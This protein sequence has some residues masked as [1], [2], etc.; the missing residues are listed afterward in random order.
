[1]W[2]SKW[3]DLFQNKKINLLSAIEVNDLLLYLL[4]TFSVFLKIYIYPIQAIYA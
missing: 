2:D 3:F 4:L 1:M